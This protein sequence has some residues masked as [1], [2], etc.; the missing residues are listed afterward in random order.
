M[1]ESKNN[2]VTHGLSGKVGDLLVFYQRNLSLDLIFD[3]S[4]VSFYK[5]NRK[6]NW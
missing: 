1:A 6:S 3:E 4:N 2:I 5:M